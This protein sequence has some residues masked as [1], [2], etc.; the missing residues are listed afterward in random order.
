MTWTTL[1]GHLGFALIA[2]S[3]MV[4]DLLWLRTIAILGSLAAILYNYFAPAEPLWLVIGWNTAFAVVNV[5]QI[6]LSFRER[7]RVKLSEEEKDLFE[8]SFQAFTPV[9]FMKIMRL[10]RW[11]HREPGDVLTTEGEAVPS[12]LMIYNGEV[13]IAVRGRHVSTLR[14]GRFVA[15]MSF[16]SGSKAAATTTVKKRSRLVCWDRD[17]LRALLQRNPTLRFN[18]QAVLTHDLYKK[19]Q[20]EGA[21]THTNMAFPS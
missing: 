12:L 21:T 3:F 6:A 14:D 17:Q 5:V 11:E 20:R 7:A 15:E 13:E 1:A 18:F 19:L 4:R 8:T 16:I 9:E 10:A 2:L